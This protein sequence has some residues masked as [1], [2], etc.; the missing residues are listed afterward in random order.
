MPDNLVEVWRPGMRAIESSP[1]GNASATEESERALEQA[2]G[3][4][5]WGFLAERN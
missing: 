4:N 5:D 2:R 3:A 1:R